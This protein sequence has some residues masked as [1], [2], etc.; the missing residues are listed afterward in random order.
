MTEA[1]ADA[2]MESTVEGSSA[3][4]LE[5]TSSAGADAAFSIEDSP[6][7]ELETKVDMEVAFDVEVDV[8]VNLDVVVLEE[9]EADNDA[10]A[11]VEVEADSECEA[12]LEEVMLPIPRACSMSTTISSIRP[13]P[14][15]TLKWVENI[16]ESK[17]SLRRVRPPC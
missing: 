2:I 1:V 12:E 3:V 13:S 15:T 16:R 14:E 11:D 8:D 7:A 4:T 17:A 9:A 6:E 10:D 5:G